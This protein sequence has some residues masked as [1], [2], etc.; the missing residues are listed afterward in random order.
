MGDKI[1]PQNS[2][3][4]D[5]KQQ[6]L[7]PVYTV[8]NIQH[9]VR[10]LDGVKVSYSS[11][12]KLF[13]LHA[14]G[15]DV[16]CHV[17]GSPAPDKDT[18]EF[19]AWEKI[20]AVVL[21]WIYGTLSDELLARVLNDASTTHEA[22]Q[23]VK[24]LFVNNK[25]SRA[26]ALQ[27]EPTNL[28]LAS[29]PNL[30]SYCQKI[31]DLSDQLA[32]VDYPMNDSQRVLH[33]VHGLPKEYDTIASILNQSL[34][35]WEDA[36]DQLQSEARRIATREAVTPTPMVAAAITNTTPPSR[37]HPPP[38]VTT[39]DYPNQRPSQRRNNNNRSGRPNS[40][41]QRGPTSSHN[42]PAAHQAQFYP[43]MAQQQFYPP[44]WAPP[45]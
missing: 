1:D 30:E 26:Q 18:P 7:H 20:D 34:L 40:N 41:N 23:R 6:P 27:H 36:I 35:T 28:T 8:T 11:W 31:R 32:A 2:A 14:K 29:M 12:V 9:K 10:V 21:Q 19:L 15:Y 13:L 42:R 24:R 25:G 44:Y 39:Q 16:L 33:L 22:R 37:D 4:T 3:T 38:P 5:P 17:D 43:P 45:Y